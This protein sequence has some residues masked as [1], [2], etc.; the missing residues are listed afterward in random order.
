MAPPSN[1]RSFP[2][3]LRDRAHEAKSWLCV[4][5][6]PELGRLPSHLPRSVPGVVEFCRVII[7]HTA[8]LAACFKINFA[9]F[10]ALGPDGWRALSE[11][12][13]LVPDGIPVIADAKRGDIGN[14]ARAYA[15][16][17]FEALGFDAATVNPY[18]G[19]D[20]LGPFLTHPGKGVLV[21]CKTSNPGA[22]EYQDILTDGEPLYMRVARKAVAARGPAEVGLVVGATQPD[23]LRAVRALD[24]NIVFLMPGVGAQG[25]TAAHAVA[26]GANQKGDNALASASRDVLYASSGR[27]FGEDARAVA[28]RMA[29][30]SWVRP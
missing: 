19:W 20:S 11:V 23:A 8:D 28:E 1:I 16:A 3:G 2:A 7:D 5:L 18:L 25:A 9:F 21:L 27:D 17:L 29:A 4:G 10:E 14:T 6:D 24:E 26:D 13:Y 12:R 30:Q 15:R 22:T